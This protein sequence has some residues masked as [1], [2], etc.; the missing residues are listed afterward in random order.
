VVETIRDAARGGNVKKVAVVGC[1]AYMKSGYG[2]PGEWR[3]LKA[4]ALGE[5]NFD[6]P[7]QVVAF[8]R[9][10]C[11]GRTVAP[12]L[13][14]ASKLSEIQPDLIYFSSCLANAKPECP[15]VSPAELAKI[16]EGKTGVEVILGTHPYH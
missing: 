3:C 16:V 5:G 2:C 11:P 1:G 4:A 10:E 7:S 13:T 15:Y 12:N 14:M 8:I 9:C 6:E